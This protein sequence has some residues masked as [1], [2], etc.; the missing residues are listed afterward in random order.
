MKVG[1]IVWYFKKKNLTIIKS[2][3][4]NIHVEWYYSSRLVDYLME[5]GDVISGDFNIYDNEKDC[6]LAFNHRIWSKI[7]EKENK[8]EKLKDEIKSLKEKLI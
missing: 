7:N 1:D 3:I 6:I 2:K 5:N 8:I 4:K